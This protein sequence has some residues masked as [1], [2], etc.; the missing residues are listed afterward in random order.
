MNIV[1]KLKEGKKRTAFNCSVIAFRH[2]PEGW[3]W[4]QRKSLTGVCVY[5]DKKIYAPSPITRRALQVFLHE[6]AHATLH[7]E[8]KNGKPQYVKEYEAELW[9][10]RV[11]RENGIR[12]SRK[13][14]ESAKAFVGWRISMAVRRGLK[15]VDKKIKRWIQR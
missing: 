7:A 9:A 11:M 1:D 8:R 6:C 2:M 13:M 4:I 10:F 3:R 14:I 12:V 15:N 5:E